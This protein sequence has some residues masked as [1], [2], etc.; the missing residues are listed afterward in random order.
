MY[1][2]LLTD[3]SGSYIHDHINRPDKLNALNNVHLGAREIVAGNLMRI[4]R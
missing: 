2:T 3:L 4:R 1:Q